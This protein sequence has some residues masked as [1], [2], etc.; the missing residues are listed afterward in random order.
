MNHN[1]HPNSLKR[2]AW[3]S[4]EKLYMD[5]HDSEWGI[6]QYDDNVLFEMLILEGLQA[7]LNW[8]TVLK[9]RLHYREVCYEF[10]ARKIVSHFPS[11]M[12]QLLMDKRLIRNRLK[13]QAIFINA[14]MYLAL[15]KEEGAFSPYIWHFIGG[16]PK[17]N[18][19][20]TKSDVPV[21]TVESERMS[22]DLK[23][24]GFKFVGATICYAYMQAVGMVM[25]HTTDCFRYHELIKR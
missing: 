18:H 9:K 22:R 16:K 20:K 23:K 1:N 12:E 17:I 8:Y 24:R 11:N 3:V 21:K 14:K 25:D 15:V 10:D 19:W 6:P 2:C 13:M 7:G 4:Q 5:Y